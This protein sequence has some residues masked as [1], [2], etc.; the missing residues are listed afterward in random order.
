MSCWQ[1]HKLDDEYLPSGPSRLNKK[2]RKISKKSHSATP[3]NV[4]SED[5]DDL[6]R[7][8]LSMCQ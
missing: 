8:G 5:E 4:Y 2:S 7:E 3:N 6:T 1:K